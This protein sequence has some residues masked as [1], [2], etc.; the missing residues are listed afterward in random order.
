[1]ANPKF[2]GP[3]QMSIQSNPLRRG[4]PLLGLPPAL[5]KTKWFG[6]RSRSLLKFKAEISPNYF[7]LG[8]NLNFS[9]MT[10]NFP[11]A[12]WDTWVKKTDGSLMHFDIIVH[13][14][15]SEA[16]IVFKF[17]RE[18]LQQKGLGDLELNSKV[19]SFCHV[20]ECREDWRESILQKGY[21]IYEMQGCN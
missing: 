15:D 19:C 8:I 21:A 11:V 7:D 20:E 14:K 5:L 18:Y 4:H 3:K 17:G 1:M 16:E 12:V 2:S 10:K 9:K 13:S 6:R